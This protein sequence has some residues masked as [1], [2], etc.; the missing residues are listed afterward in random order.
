MYRI[1]P[2]SYSPSSHFN[3]YYIDVCL[4]PFILIIVVIFMDPTGVGAHV[5]HV[6]YFL[7]P[8]TK[9]TLSRLFLYDFL[10]SSSRLLFHLRSMHEVQM[11]R[12][13]DMML[14]TR[15]GCNEGSKGLV[16]SDTIH[17]VD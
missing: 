12:S 15:R 13:M 6:T 17:Q 4:F 8:E 5:H 3:V 2:S 16:H 1:N 7:V 10:S 9:V 14:D 11:P